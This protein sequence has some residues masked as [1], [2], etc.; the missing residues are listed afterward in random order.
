MDKDILKKVDS[1]TSKTFMCTFFVL[2]L[3]VPLILYKFF[4]IRFENGTYAVI[5]FACPLILAAD[6]EITDIRYKAFLKK[7][8]PAEYDIIYDTEYLLFDF[9]TSIGSNH[10]LKRID[11]VLDDPDNADDILYILYVQIL[12]KR[13]LFSLLWIPGMAFIW[14]VHGFVLMKI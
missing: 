7:Y 12:S 5:M 3:F 10:E 11:R 4:N 6:A 14:I 9:H 1:I 2:V 13:K 8:Y